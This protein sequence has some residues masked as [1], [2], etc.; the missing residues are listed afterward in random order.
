MGLNGLMNYDDICEL[1]TNAIEM[2]ER[3]EDDAYYGLAEDYCRDA[4]DYI[5]MM[6][7]H[8][9]NA[10]ITR[11]SLQWIFHGIMELY[12]RNLAFGFGHA[13]NEIIIPNKIKG[14]I[15]FVI[16]NDYVAK[17]NKVTIVT[18]DNESGLGLKIS[19]GAGGEELIDVAAAV[20]KAWNCISLTADE[21]G[22]SLSGDSDEFMDALFAHS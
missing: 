13:V 5:D 8:G 2:Q 20:D 15:F 17:G 4:I 22:V 18:N 10:D 6:R 7:K 3:G 14:Y 19:D 9:Y 1:H 21:K 11:D 12:K 16:H